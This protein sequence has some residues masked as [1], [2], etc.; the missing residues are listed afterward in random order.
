M[1]VNL[2]SEPWAEEMDELRG[3]ACSGWE[4]AWHAPKRATAEHRYGVQIKAIVIQEAGLAWFC[5]HRLPRANGIESRVDDVASIAVARRHWR[6]KDGVDGETLLRTLMAWAH[7]KRRVCSMARAP[8]PSQA[9]DDR[10]TR[11]ETD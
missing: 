2:D 10:R 8:R 6:A 3:R 11:K 9:D 1:T 4:R 7:D 5:I